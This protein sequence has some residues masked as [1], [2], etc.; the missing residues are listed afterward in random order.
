MNP[1]QD[2]T[3]V[4]N[5][6]SD[7]IPAPQ[8]PITP[9][10]NPTIVTPNNS[11]NI[12]PPV[13][14]P[15]PLTQPVEPNNFAVNTPSTD[16][17]SNPTSVPN[18]TFGPPTTTFTS[19]APIPGPVSNTIPSHNSRAI[20]PKQKVLILAVLALLL[21]SVIGFFA[22]STFFSKPSQQDYLAA[23]SVID[24]LREPYD[25]MTQTFISSSATETEIKNGLDT[26]KNSR[27][28]FNEK[29]DALGDNK[30]IKKDKELSKLYAAIDAKKPNFDKATDAAIEAYEIIAPALSDITSSSS[31]NT[32]AS[33][34]TARTKIEAVSGLKDEN[35][36]QLIQN[37]TAIL[38]EMESLIPTIE[39]GRA[40]FKKYDSAAVRTF[41]T[42]AADLSSAIRDWRSNLQKMADDGEI[43]Q[44]INDLDEKLF[45]KVV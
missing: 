20:K 30:A 32:L 7:G 23:Q 40:D 35:N 29:L 45:E 9:P 43:N 12:E 4:N 24:D 8:T 33:I 26:I 22:Y 3:P 10:V 34:T 42:K 44:E 14:A 38:K 25:D 18:P 19:P 6:S 39:A 1:D 15:L 11:I 13:V 21:V 31:D 36:K 41:S 28:E 27:T 5:I 2:T 17:I 16:A 37:L